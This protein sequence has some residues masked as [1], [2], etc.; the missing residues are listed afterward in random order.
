[1]RALIVGGS[2]FVGTHLTRFLVEKGIDVAIMAR[3]PERGPGVPEKVGLIAA[4]A[5]KPG[6]WQDEVGRHDVIINLAG[7]STFRRW[8]ENY[9]RLLKESRVLTTANVVDA[10]PSDAGDRITLLNASGA[11]VYGW[12]GDEKLDETGLQGSDFLARLARAWEEEAIKAERK[13]ARVVR[14][15]LGIVLGND[16]GALSQMVRPFRFFAG[17]P[18][19]NGRQWISWIH[20]Q[21]LCRAA[22]F[23]MEN[24]NMRGPV[25]FTSPEPVR[26]ADLAKAIGKIMNRPSFMPAPAFM[27]RLVLGEFGEYALKGQRAVPKALLDAGFRFAFGTIEEALL[28]LL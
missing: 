13:G 15:R 18:I 19:G 16:G 26:N 27:I 6:K 22:L 14:A 12:T 3:K 24:T 8:D 7:V 11:G 21:D 17:G 10:I 5:T 1:M 9:K 4:D 28:D 25:N 20:V 23:V 2:G